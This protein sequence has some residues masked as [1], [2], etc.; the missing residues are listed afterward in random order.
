MPGVIT[1]EM[2]GEYFPLVFTQQFVRVREKANFPPRKGGLRTG[3]DI[4]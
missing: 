2:T 1:G 4:S 3:I